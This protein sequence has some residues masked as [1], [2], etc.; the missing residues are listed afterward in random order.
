MNFSEKIKVAQVGVA[1]FGRYRRERLRESGLF[2]L[3]AAHDFNPE[4][5]AAC[6]AE[7]GA[8]PVGGYDELLETPGIEAV[9]ICS[10]GKDHAD[11][12]VRAMEKGLHVFVEKPLCSTPEEVGLLL[13]T[14]RRTGRVVGVGH[15]D[16]STCRVS[17]ATK[18]LIDDGVL[19]SIA[20]FEKTTAH[21]GGLQIKP[22]DWRGDPAKNP[23]G[24]LFQC[25]VH[26]FHELMYYFGPI[27]DVSALMRHDVHTTGTADVAICH[28]QFASGLVGT[29]NAYHV[30]PYRHTLSLYGTKA[31]LYRNDRYFSEGTSMQIQK[32]SGSNGE[33]PLEP[34]PL[35]GD[36]DLCGNLRNFYRAI[37]EGGECYP[38]L[39]DGALAVQVVFAAEESARTRRVVK[40][41]ELLG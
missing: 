16:H 20:T 36:D 26:G 23:G 22:G 2:D 27:T 7:D 24:M 29:L 35:P 13:E 6:E 14:Q 19:G 11:H 37:R 28:L 32:V 30:T 33:E 12:M 25:G 41:P 31:N 21:S 4:A 3:V 5:L 38:S 8:R 15:A 39:R 34:V 10:G 1:N 17:R 18:R 40:I 9:I